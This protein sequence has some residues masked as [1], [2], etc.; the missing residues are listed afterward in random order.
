MDQILADDKSRR[1]F[2]FLVW[3]D[4]FRPSPTLFRHVGTGLSGLTSTKQ[5]VKCLAQGHN[6]VPPV[7]LETTTPRSQVKH[8]IIELSR[9][10]DAL[11]SHITCILFVTQPKEIQPKIK[12][13]LTLTF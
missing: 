9:S 11:L 7:R 1:T 3:F 8:S 10:L 13:N 12:L 2:I 5:R 6:A 4:P